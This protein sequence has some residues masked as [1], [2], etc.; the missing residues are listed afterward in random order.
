[1][2][3]ATVENILSMI[4]AL[5]DDERVLLQERL[6]ERAEQAWQTET[7]AARR[8]AQRRGI[9]QTAID[10]AIRKRRYGS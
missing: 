7:E 9:D 1:M 6:D 5:A 10:E 8:E 4:D 3:E 2:S